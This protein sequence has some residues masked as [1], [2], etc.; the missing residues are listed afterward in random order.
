MIFFNELLGFD[1][2]TLQGLLKFNLELFYFFDEI[3][4]LGEKFVVI[5]CPLII[6]F[7]DTC[8]DASPSSFYSQSFSGFQDFNT[9]NESL[10]SRDIIILQGFGE[11][12]G[13]D[14]INLGLEIE[15]FL[16]KYSQLLLLFLFQFGSGMLGTT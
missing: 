6:D 14:L 7:P 13:Q 12:C 9:I 4:C 16:S 5:R 15:K 1:F 3:S 11:D 2:L 8:L 10:W